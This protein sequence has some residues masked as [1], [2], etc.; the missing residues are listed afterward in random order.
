M[1]FLCDPLR[2]LRLKIFGSS[3]GPAL[4]ALLEAKE[5]SSLSEHNWVKLCECHHEPTADFKALI[6]ATPANPVL[7]GLK[8]TTGMDLNKRDPNAAASPEELAMAKNM[9]MT[10]AEFRGVPA[11]A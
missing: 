4:V 3:C 2:S 5:W 6:A 7:A 10:L 9:G 11:A 8:Q 1:V